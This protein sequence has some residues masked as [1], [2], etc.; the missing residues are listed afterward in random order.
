M[1]FDDL[2]NEAACGCCVESIAALFQNGHRNRGAK[3]MGRTH[4]TE[5]PTKFGAGSES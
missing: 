1:R 4:G 5:R 2:E 3:P